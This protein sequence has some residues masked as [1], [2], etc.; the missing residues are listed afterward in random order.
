ME[1]GMD[2]LLPLQSAEDVRRLLKARR[3]GA[4]GGWRCAPVVPVQQLELA[5]FSLERAL[6][7]E[8]KV[9]S[10]NTNR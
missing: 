4:A 7:A 10:E 1:M 3:G 9:G 5:N 8:R 6:T 2:G